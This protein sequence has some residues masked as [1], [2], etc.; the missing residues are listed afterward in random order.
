MNGQISALAA[1]MNGPMISRPAVRGKRRQ[2]GQ[3]APLVLPAGLDPKQRQNR[4]YYAQNRERL[5]AKRRHPLK[6]LVTFQPVSEGLPD[7]ELLVLVTTDQGEVWPAFLDE[8]R[9]LNADA[10]TLSDKVLAWA[11][12]PEPAIVA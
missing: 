2:A 10:S 7:D 1:L 9:W 4:T 12:M 8:G 5:L 11:D 6:R 3:D